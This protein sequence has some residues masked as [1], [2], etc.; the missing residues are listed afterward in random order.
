[1]RLL[2]V[3]RSELCVGE[4]MQSVQGQP[5]NIS[6]QLKVL[7]HAGMVASRKEGR[8]VY[9]RLGSTQE[10]LAEMIFKLIK[11]LP[12]EDGEFEADRLRFLEVLEQRGQRDGVASGVAESSDA[13]KSPKRTPGKVDLSDEASTREDDG[14]SEDLPSY[15]L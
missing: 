5:Y 8:H 7:G 10:P 15:L 14:S 6:K 2:V 1:M 4:L 11:D 3:T 12:D 9:Y 13:E